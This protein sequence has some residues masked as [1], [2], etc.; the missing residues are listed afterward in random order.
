MVINA[1]TARAE[2]ADRVARQSQEMLIIAAA[3]NDDKMREE[4]L[5]FAYRLKEQ[6]TRIRTL[7]A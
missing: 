6:V 4:L 5:D 7:A 1:V 2:W 3:T